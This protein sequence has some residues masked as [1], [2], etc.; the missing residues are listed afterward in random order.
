MSYPISPRGILRKTG[1]GGRPLYHAVAR[2]KALCA[3]YLR[4]A[5]LRANAITLWASCMS[6]FFGVEDAERRGGELIARALHA[7]RKKADA[8]V[9]RRRQ[10]LLGSKKGQEGHSD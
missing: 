2:G 9:E 8:L 5:P 7:R 3:V 1:H 6:A 4:D 10:C